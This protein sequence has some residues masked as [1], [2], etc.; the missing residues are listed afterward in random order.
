MGQTFET[1]RAIELVDELLDVFAEKVKLVLSIGE[2]EKTTPTNTDKA[3]NRHKAVRN[4]WSVYRAVK[5][6]NPRLSPKTLRK[7]TR[8][9]IAES[10]LKH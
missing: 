4:F 5:E 2:N 7:K 6:G 8:T 1:E 9:V 10:G 3:E